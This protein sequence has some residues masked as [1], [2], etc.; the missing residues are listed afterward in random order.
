M[1]QFQQKYY[2]GQGNN[3]QVVKSIIKQRLWWCPAQ[4]EDFSEATF[5]WTSWKRDKHI[6]YLKKDLKTMKIYSR[7]DNNK[8]L[9]NKKGIFFNMREYYEMIGMNP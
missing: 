7:I 5:I 9:T 8:Q 6:E 2:I 3:F 1:G 4:T